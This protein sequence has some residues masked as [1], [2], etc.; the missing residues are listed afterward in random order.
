MNAGSLSCLQ[1]ARQ[2]SPS[3][4]TPGIAPMVPVAGVQARIITKD[5]L[6]VLFLIASCC[7]EL[8]L[9]GLLGFYRADPRLFDFAC[10][11]ALLVTAGDL[12]RTSQGKAEGRWIVRPLAFLLGAAAFATLATVLFLIPRHLARY[13]IFY[14]GR[15]VQLA[16]AVWFV[17]TARLSRRQT[18]SIL[19]LFLAAALVPLL[20][21]ALQYAGVV[22]PQR[23]L[24][25]GEAIPVVKGRLTSVLGNHYSHYSMFSLLVIVVCFILWS[26][27]S[28]WAIWRHLLI[29][30]SG[31]LAVAGI[32]ISGSRAGPYGLVLFVMVVAL[33]SPFTQN[34]TKY[35]AISGLVVVTSFLLVDNVIAPEATA[36]FKH[37]VR[38]LLPGS[39]QRSRRRQQTMVAER[40]MTGI[41]GI[42][43]HL[44]YHGPI[45]LLYGTGFYAS[46]ARGIIRKG[47]GIHSVPFFPLEQM[48]LPGFLA[49]IYLFVALLR[50]AHRFARHG[51]ARFHT[52][53]GDAMFAWWIVILCVGLGGQVFWVFQGFANFSCLQLC[54]TAL[55]L[56]AG[57]PSATGRPLYWRSSGMPFVTRD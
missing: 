26:S 17:A 51:R 2:A 42:A 7:Y 18:L 33:R 22:S 30:V 36:R 21:G 31:A 11:F 45:M 27:G 50:R 34:W 6:A 43:S 5:F 35:F 25:S 23:Y 15:Y 48:G 10:L 41:R 19:Y 16:F 54:L 20:V 9:F 40:S 24:E 53:A 12:R 39:E 28:S 13:P 37:S 52:C 14:L 49:A 57:R 56:G 4:E 47:Y 55:L 44:D 3:S 1:R 32:F 8:P 29:L 46:N 38:E